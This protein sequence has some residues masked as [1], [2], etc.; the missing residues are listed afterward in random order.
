MQSKLNMIQGYCNLRFQW[1][2]TVEQVETVVE[3]MQ[4]PHSDGLRLIDNPI[5]THKDPRFAQTFEIFDM[6][7]DETP[8]PRGLYRLCPPCPSA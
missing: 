4:T 6:I 5:R 3:H 1:E 7:P 8:R 2:L